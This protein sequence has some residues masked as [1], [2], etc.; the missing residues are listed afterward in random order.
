[1]LDN[2]KAGQS[3][4]GGEKG[5]CL[6][7]WTGWTLGDESRGDR[8]QETGQ[9]RYLG[10]CVAD[11]AMGGAISPRC[12]L[13]RTAC[14]EKADAAIGGSRPAKACVGTPRLGRREGG[15]NPCPGTSVSPAGSSKISSNR[16]GM[17]GAGQ[18]STTLAKPINPEAFHVKQTSEA[19][20]E[21]D[22][23]RVQRDDGEDKVLN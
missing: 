15:I 7:S 11:G 21:R 2:A 23:G 6:E 4:E 22:C 20:G 8:R 17:S 3:L 10:W 18:A 1:M 14:Q 16:G 9:D 13:S 19:M 12:P 5:A